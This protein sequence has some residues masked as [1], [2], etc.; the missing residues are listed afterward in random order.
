MRVRGSLPGAALPAWL[1]VMALTLAPRSAGAELRLEGRA[2]LQG[3]GAT[4]AYLVPGTVEPEAVGLLQLG[5]GL[6]HHRP[7]HWMRAGYDFSVQSLPLSGKWGLFHRG[8]LAGRL[9]LRRSGRLELSLRGGAIDFLSEGAVATGSSLDV[10][11]TRARYAGFALGGSLRI[12][13]TRLE[14]RL[15]AEYRSSRAQLSG[16][17]NDTTTDP[18]DEVLIEGRIG[19][20]HDT[21]H[22][23]RLSLALVGSGRASDSDYLSYG[24]GGLELGVAVVPRR[25]T[26]IQA[27]VR[28]QL[29]AYPA[30]GDP[31]FQRQDLFAR[32]WLL[33]R[34]RLA[35]GVWLGAVWSYSANGSVEAAYDADRHL[36][37]LTLQLEGALLRW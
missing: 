24:G 34:Q 36:A 21:G 8:Q 6:S 32:V 14:S 26:S 13:R 27:L 1:L 4:R 9:A 35:E 12:G 5:L 23:T 11:A 29:N 33:L 30:G 16:S 10:V 3:G 19:V 17:G 31:A 7:R 22:R 2:E 18:L 37:L 28:S 20:D 15:D 25:G